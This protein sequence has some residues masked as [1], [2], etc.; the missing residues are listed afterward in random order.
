MAD[1]IE[2]EPKCDELWA[3]NV[4]YR[5]PRPTLR[6]RA[7]KWMQKRRMRRALLGVKR[8][9]KG[10]VPPIEDADTVELIQCEDDGYVLRIRRMGN[11]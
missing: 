2:I 6:M 4:C 9:F 1:T 11:G 10:A 7:Y 8:L 3:E 5:V